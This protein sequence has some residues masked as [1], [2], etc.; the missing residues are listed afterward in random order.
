[1]E[2]TTRFYAWMGDSAAHRAMPLAAMR[3]AS[4]PTATLGID[5]VHAV[6]IAGPASDDCVALS[7]QM[8]PF[9]R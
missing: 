5:E 6:R 9:D 7:G 1:M 8:V 2:A 3:L 4:L